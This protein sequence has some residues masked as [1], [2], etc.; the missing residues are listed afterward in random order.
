MSGWMA[1]AWRYFLPIHSSL[2]PSMWYFG[3]R[4][5]SLGLWKH[6]FD[7]R[8]GVVHRQADADR[9]QER[10]VAQ[11]LGPGARIQLAL[12]HHVEVGHR[13][14]RREEQRHVDEQHLV[15]AHVVADDHR[16]RHQH[17]QHAH[18]RVVEVGRQV[19]ERLGLHLERLIRP[20]D[21][22]H[23]LQEGLDRALGPAVLLALERVHLDRQFGRGDV[24]GQ[25]HELPALELRAVAEVEV[26]GERVVLPAAA[27][28]DRRRGARCRPCR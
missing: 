21:V 22:R 12:A 7:H 14:R 18:Q 25:E 11:A 9:H 15:P 19:E 17:R 24:V 20:Q 10:Q 3:V 26:F 28:D 13:R 4:V 27:V 8:L 2:P 23:Q 5:N 1:T 6:R 16:R